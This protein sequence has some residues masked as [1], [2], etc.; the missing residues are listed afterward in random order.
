MPASTEARS[1]TALASSSWIRAHCRRCALRW[2]S[3]AGSVMQAYPGAPGAP[4]S[5]TE[6]KGE[7]ASATTAEQAQDRQHHDRAEHGAE[8]T[9]RFTGGVPAHVLAE[10]AGQQR[11]ENAQHDGQ[12]AAHA[13]VAGH[14][15]APKQADQE[16]D[17]DD[18]EPAAAAEQTIHVHA[19]R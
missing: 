10:P 16:A 6:G 5:G 13:V 7:S 15:E 11:A 17:Q 1:T 2:G 8:E 4:T 18:V 19:F 12:Q 9:G 14:E 3:E